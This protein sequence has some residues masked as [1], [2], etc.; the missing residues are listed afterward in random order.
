MLE[1]EAVGKGRCEEGRLPASVRGGAARTAAYRRAHGPE[2]RGGPP[3]GEGVDWSIE[4]GRLVGE[5]AAWIVENG[6]LPPSATGVERA[7]RSVEDG[8]PRR[9]GASRRASCRGARRGGASRRASCRGA[10]RGSVEEGLLQGS[11]AGRNVEESCRGARRGGASTR[12]SLQGSAAGERGG[13]RPAGERSSH[14]PATAAGERGGGRL[15]GRRE[16]CGDGDG[17]SFRAFP[18]SQARKV[19]QSIYT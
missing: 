6:G 10:R 12:A 16:G 3:A 15:G 4:D 9:G 19:F 7:G 11:T 14:L 8:V 5:R 1:R 17:G 13:R 2:L 18:S